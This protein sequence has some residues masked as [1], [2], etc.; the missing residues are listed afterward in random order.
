MTGWGPPGS[1][2]A[3]VAGGSSGIGLASARRLLD[4]RAKLVI[5]GAEESEVTG[6]AV[7]FLANP[8]ASF[9]TGTELKVDGGLLAALGVKLR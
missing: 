4:E 5:A 6:A 3:A 8:A 9:V 1:W 7:W 2:V